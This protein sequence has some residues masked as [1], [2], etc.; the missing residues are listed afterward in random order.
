MFSKTTENVGREARFSIGGL[1]SIS[2]MDYLGNPLTFTAVDGV[3][4]LTIKMEPIYIFDLPDD[5]DVVQ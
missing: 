4:D 3:I 2:G 5:F 1:E